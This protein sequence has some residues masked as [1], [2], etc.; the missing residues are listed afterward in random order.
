VTTNC[1]CEC[2]ISYGYDVTTPTPVA[3]LS[4][5][6]VCGYW[7]AGIAGSNPAEGINVRPL[8]LLCAV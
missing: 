4:K 2:E 5:A 8:C 1:N 7:S 3:V 6:W